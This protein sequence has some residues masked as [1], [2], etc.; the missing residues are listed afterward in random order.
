M[1]MLKVSTPEEHVGSF[2]PSR[3]AS[4]EEPETEGEINTVQEV[5]NRSPIKLDGNGEA[6]GICVHSR[7]RN[8]SGTRTDGIVH[9]VRDDRSE[10]AHGS[11]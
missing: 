5:A 3:E 2:E 1:D 6:P 11:K 7:P 8:L 10:D 9:R 4:G